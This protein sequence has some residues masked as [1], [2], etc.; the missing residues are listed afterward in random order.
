MVARA[1]QAAVP[2]I[3]YL[4]AGRSERSDA[5]IAALNFHRG[6]SEIG[7]FEGRNLAVEYRWAD[8]HY[9]RLPAMA[10]DLVRRQVTVITA[11]AIGAALAAKAATRTVPIVFNVGPHVVWRQ[12]AQHVPASCLLR[13]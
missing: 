6:L 12:P 3:G 7:Y 8:G 11:R 10:A 1:Q 9:D 13:A 5:D 2:A 4:D